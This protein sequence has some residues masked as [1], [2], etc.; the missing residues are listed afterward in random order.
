MGVC[1]SLLDALGLVQSTW[2]RKC[3]HQQ[4]LNKYGPVLQRPAWRVGP[5]KTTQASQPWHS[6][7]RGSVGLPP[8][9]LS[10]LLPLNHSF[11]ASRSP[12]L[13]EVWHYT[14]AAWLTPRTL[15]RGTWE[16][17]A[18]TGCILTGP[19]QCAWLAPACQ[20]LRLVLPVTSPH[21]VRG[22][23]PV[24][25]TAGKAEDAEEACPFHQTSFS[26]QRPL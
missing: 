24:L 2:N 17:L 6:P 1:R 18:A 7:A 5:S 20:L 4:H 21:M 16:P 19:D 22:L 23:L 8:P 15:A 9:V 10:C 3:S 25:V 14:P 12:R 26:R 11:P 13:R